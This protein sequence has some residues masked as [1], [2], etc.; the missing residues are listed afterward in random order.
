MLCVYFNHKQSVIGRGTI[1]VNQPCTAVR[2]EERGQPH[3][4]KAEGFNPCTV[5]RFKLCAGSSPSR[6]AG[7]IEPFC[8][9]E[10]DGHST[11]Y[12]NNL[13][14]Y[15]TLIARLQ[16]QVP[17]MRI[18][19]L[20]LQTSVPLFLKCGVYVQVASLWTHSCSDEQ[21]DCLTP[22]FEVI[23]L[24]Q[25]G[26]FLELANGMLFFSEVDT[27][28]AVVIESEKLFPVLSGEL[29]M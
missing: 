10:I 23:L 22:I 28:P 5:A 9:F 2:C 1:L 16:S 12:N 8:H 21:A 13:S 17:G 25:G 7:S 29:H 4:P 20:G 14:S 19:R 18:T 26:F 11:C 6:R 24:L 15:I 3:L 27:P